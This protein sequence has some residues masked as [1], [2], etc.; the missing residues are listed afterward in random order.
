MLFKI[1]QA[2]FDYQGHVGAKKNPHI[3]FP[4][5][6]RDLRWHCSSTSLMSTLAQT[7]SLPVLF[8]VN[9]S[10]FTFSVSFSLICAHVSGT[11]RI[12]KVRFQ[13]TGYRE[14]ECQWGFVWLDDWE[15][16]SIERK[17]NLGHEK[18]DVQRCERYSGQERG[19]REQNV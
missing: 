19:R 13:R 14:M 2:L 8:V 17:T 15:I 16:K 9:R 1:R 4:L 18:D 10:S 6:A 7:S 12:G 5:D 11:K 3:S